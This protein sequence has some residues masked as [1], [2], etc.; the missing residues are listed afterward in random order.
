LTLSLNALATRV[1]LGYNVEVRAGEL[2]PTP[3][4]EPDTEDSVDPET[5]AATDAIRSKQKSLE[6]MNVS[7]KPILRL[8]Q[9]EEPSKD[10]Q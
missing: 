3:D 5:R 6:F 10:E 9:P 1:D 8:E 7:G 4:D 2:P